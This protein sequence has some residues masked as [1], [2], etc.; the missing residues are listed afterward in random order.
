MW[1]PA[2]VAIRA[3]SILVCMPPRES[4]EPAAPAIASISGVMRGTQGMCRA[5]ASLSGGAS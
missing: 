1:V 2:L 5:P 3:A 4:S